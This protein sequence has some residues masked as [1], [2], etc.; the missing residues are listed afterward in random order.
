MGKSYKTFFNCNK[1]SKTE[2]KIEFSLTL[3]FNPF[4]PSVTFH[5]ETSRFVLQNQ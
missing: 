4:Q 1:A 5:M 3:Y 2:R